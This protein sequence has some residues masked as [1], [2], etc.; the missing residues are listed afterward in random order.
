ME[1]LESKLGQGGREVR[2]KGPRKMKRH[3]V[4]VALK[5]NYGDLKIASFLRFARS[6]VHK[7]CRVRKQKNK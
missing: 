2:E 3:A 1:R 4:I 5:G 6:F 7:I